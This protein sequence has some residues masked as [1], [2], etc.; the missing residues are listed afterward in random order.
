MKARRGF[1]LVELLVVI[2]I[3]GVLVALLLPA[4]QA[5]REAARRSD[6]M[7][8][9]KQLGVAAHTYLSANED[10]PYSEFTWATRCV[11]DPPR[12]GARLP[13]AGGNGTSFLFR[14][15]PHLE[16]QPLYNQFVTYNALKGAFSENNGLRGGLSAADRN[17]LR[18]LVQ[19]VLPAF[20]CP[21]D[22]FAATDAFVRDQPDYPG[23]ALASTN[24]KGC[25][26]N[27][28]VASQSFSWNPPQAGEIAAGDWHDTD[29]CNTGLLWRNDY[30]LKNARWKSLGDG[31][32]NTFLIGESLPEFDQHSSWPFANGPWA[33][34]SIPPNY[35]IG[36]TKDELLKLRTEHWESLGF[37]SRHVGSVG[38]CFADGS[39]RF[40]NETIAMTVYRALSTRNQGE[41]N[42]SEAL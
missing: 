39:V 25:V 13:G 7:N 17:A 6:C 21:S 35:A 16:Q 29:Q 22:D 27:T 23:Q 42:N 33:T 5:A 14:L 32:S 15:L 30:L 3:I 26:G 34:C 28:L 10:L 18:E 12:R 24:F 31:S 11:P 8:R 40:I 41:T 19:T 36:L 9:L 37:R 20:V 1:T 38:F 2:A 4:V